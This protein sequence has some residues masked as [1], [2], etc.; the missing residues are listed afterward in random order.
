VFCSFCGRS[1]D[2]KLCPRLHVNSR[3]AEV[4]SQ[5]GSR[6]LSMPQPKVSWWWKALGTSLRLV[7]GAFL[8]LLSL[9]GV[10]GLLTVPQIQNGVVCLAILLGALWWLWSELP[11]WMRNLAKRFLNRKERRYER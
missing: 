8:V 11:S 9:A 4:C 3:A 1:Y 7:V 10:V 6:D 2:V 5:C